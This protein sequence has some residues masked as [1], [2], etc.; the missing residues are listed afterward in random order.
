MP[1][2]SIV[3]SAQVLGEFYWIVTRRLS[4][5]LSV[6]EAA[7]AVDRLSRLSVVPLD[8]DMVLRA[9]ALSESAD[10]QY[11]DALIVQAAAAGGC[12]RLLTEDLNHGQV[13]DGVTVENPFVTFSLPIAAVSLF[14]IA[15]SP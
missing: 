1:P 3:V 12:R 11:W 13:I 7:S 14:P 5:A 2:A 4:S 15:A 6:A 10:I 8:R 9:I